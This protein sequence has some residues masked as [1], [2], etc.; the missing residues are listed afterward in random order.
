MTSSPWFTGVFPIYTDAKQAYK[1]LFVST[2]LYLCAKRL[3]G[4][5]IQ[6]LQFDQISIEI[7]CR[8]TLVSET[9]FSP[10]KAILQR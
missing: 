6:W 2:S 8:D 10:S 1:H 4:S 9:S 3:N 7:E 5:Q